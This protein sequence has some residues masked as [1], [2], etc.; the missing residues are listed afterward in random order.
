MAAKKTL[1]EINREFMELVD[2][3]DELIVDNGQF[4]N[5][6]TGEVFPLDKLDVLQLEQD[7]KMKNCLYVYKEKYPAEIAAL[8]GKI[9]FLQGEIDKLKAKKESKEKQRSS[10]GQYIIACTNGEKWKAKDGSVS[11]YTKVTLST[12]LD[13]EEILPDEYFNTKTVRTADKAKIK[14]AILAGKT[15]QGAHLNSKQTLM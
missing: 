9:N 6:E 1:W 3:L 12:V 2:Q 8:D 4:V 10:F 15:V 11:C 14:E 7:E 13:D 5:P